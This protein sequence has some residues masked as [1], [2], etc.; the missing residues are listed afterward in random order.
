MNVLLGCIAD[1]FTGATDLASFLVKSGMRT[2]QLIGI[3]SEPVDLSQA[4]AV[5]IALKSRTLPANVAVEQSIAALEWLKQF[6][7]EQYYFKY[8]S[9]F[10]S[11]KKGNIGPV[12][13]A[14]LNNLEENFT[15]I[16]PSLP[17]NGRTVYKGHLFV[18]DDLLNESGMQ[19]H[20][21]TPMTDANLLRV[22]ASQASGKVGLV[23]FEIISKGAENIQQA[24]QKFSK[25]YRYVVVDTV[26]SDDLYA[27]GKAS[28]HLKL[29]TG[30]S[31]LSVG[32]AK[33]FE[34]KGLFKIRS[35]SA[36]LSKVKGEAIVLSGSCS[37]M[38]QKQVVRFQENFQS[39][40]ISPLDIASGRTTLDDFLAWF[41]NNRNA[42]TLM[43]YATDTPE[44]IRLVQAEL[45]IEH[46][47]EIVENFMADLVTALEK[48]GITKFIVAG[49][50]TSGAVVKALKPSMLKIGESIAPGVPLTE[51]AG[52]SPKLVALKSGNF[53]DEYFFEKALEMMQ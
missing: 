8:C 33:N 5:V 20:P 37:A 32:L 42:G 28:A 35:N 25:E 4:D 29:L 16:C 27:I 3:P 51:I 14:L 18:N 19:N 13:D 45:G 12:T 43:F 44:N 11:T 7:C 21:L 23:P 46:A 26:S 47:S 1:D 6:H 30:G 17:V 50:E 34:D 31:G 38:T 2:V 40:K 10:D 22:M 41:E 15:I 24:F 48:R 52:D 49:G 9:T 36:E 39:K 53:G